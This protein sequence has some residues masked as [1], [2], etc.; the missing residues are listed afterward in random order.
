MYESNIESDL[1]IRDR[2]EES[3][4]KESSIMVEEDYSAGAICTNFKLQIVAII[5]YQE[6]IKINK[7]V[8]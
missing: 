8:R 3:Y 4:K 2:T 1:K 7:R 5:W 6:L